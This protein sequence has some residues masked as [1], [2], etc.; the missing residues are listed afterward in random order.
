MWEPQRAALEAA[1]HRVLAPDLRGFGERPLDAGPYSH[2]D[3]VRVLLDGPAA[4][5]GASFGGR[6]ALDLAL[7]SP[8]LVE[9]LVLAGAAVAGWEVSEEL[10][11]GWREEEEA[12]ERGALDEAAEANLRLWLD[13]GRPPGAVAPGVRD[14]VRRMVLRSFEL[15]LPAGDA[16]VATWMEPPALERLEAV[17]APT[18]VV[19]GADD[20]ADFRAVAEHLAGRIPGARL[21]VVEGAAH[22]P[23]LERPEAFNRLLLDFLSGGR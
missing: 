20:V 21:E 9:R 6:V 15:Q 14:L 3:D 19:V 2:V 11:A 8:E 7:A 16:A 12:L 17:L 22:L 13:R 5:V 23:S 10:E 18:L 1:G 4:V